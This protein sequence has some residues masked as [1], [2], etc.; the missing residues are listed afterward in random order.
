MFVSVAHMLRVVLYGETR[1]HD[2]GNI[3]NKWSK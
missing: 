2:S 1:Q 3:R